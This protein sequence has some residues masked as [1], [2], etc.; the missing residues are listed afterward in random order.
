MH[1]HR[2]I[3]VLLILP[4]LAFFKLCQWV[5][6]P[7]AFA[8]LLL[9]SFVTYATYWYDKQRAQSGASR[10]SEATLHSL[11]FFGGWP[12]AYLAQQQF[13][14]K[15]IKRSYQ[16]IYWCIVG[17]YQYIALEILLQWRALHGFLT[18]FR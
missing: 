3:L 16:I 2:L 18:L 12:A 10:V 14:H 7:Y 9:I 15:T 11:E 17:F 8:Y 4:I 1:T 5:Q 13:R 6:P